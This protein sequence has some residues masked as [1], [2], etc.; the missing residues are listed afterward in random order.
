MLDPCETGIF[1]ETKRGR[2]CLSVFRIYVMDLKVKMAFSQ[3]D[4]SEL[5]R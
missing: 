3:S 4:N 5:A 2:S 1:F